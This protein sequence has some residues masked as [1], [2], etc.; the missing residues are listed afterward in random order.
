MGLKIEML[1]A[2]FGAVA[3][4]GN[5]LTEVF[6]RNLFADFPAVKPLFGDVD[7]AEQKKKLLGSL[8]LTVENLRR[9]EKL[10]PALKDLGLRHLDYGAREDHYPAVGQTLLKSLREVA[11]DVWNQE[12]TDAWSEAFGEIAKTMLAGAAQPT[13]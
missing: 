3:P 2:S 6:Y 7:M 1:E 11:G 10:V 8:K 4:K 9:P 13:S 5:E 12:F